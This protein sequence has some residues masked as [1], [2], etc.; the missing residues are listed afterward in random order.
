M[1]RRIMLFTAVAACAA[2]F[3][4]P[5]ASA[6]T[7]YSGQATALNAS[8]FGNDIVVGDTGPLPSSGGS[9]SASLATINLLGLLSA[10]VLNGSTSAS[11]T[12]STSRASV[13][14]LALSLVG[15]KISAV[16]SQTTATCNGS[17]PSVSGSS[18]LVDVSLNGQSLGTI[19][20]PNVKLSVL[21]I[22]IA[23]NEE[24]SSTSGNTGDITVNA[25]HVTGPGIDIV[26]ASSHS[27]ITCG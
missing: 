22:T 5:A 26:V 14:D 19:A 18:D 20:T 13:L 24:T 2:A 4:V 16:D 3:A 6:Q 12:Q 25:V 10:S 9:Q 27:D 1:A 8:V 11:G 17:T 7:T 21:G 23:L 15:L